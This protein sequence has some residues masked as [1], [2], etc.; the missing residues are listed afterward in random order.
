MSSHWRVGLQHRNFG[1]TQ[2]FIYSSG[3][4]GRTYSALQG[5]SSWAKNQIDMKQINRRKSN[6]IYLWGIHTDMEIAKTMR[7]HDAYIS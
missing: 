3:W 5:P 6:L 1:K 2:A 7:Q 4:G